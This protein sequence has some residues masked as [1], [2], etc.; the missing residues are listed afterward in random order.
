MKKIIQ[1]LLICTF[2]TPQLSLAGTIILANDAWPTS[3]T[4]F[5]QAPSANTATSEIKPICIN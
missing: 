1:L 3:N 4:G 2:L 5:S